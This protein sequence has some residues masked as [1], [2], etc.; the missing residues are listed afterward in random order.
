MFRVRARCVLLVCVADDEVG[1]RGNGTFPAQYYLPPTSLRYG[2]EKQSSK[3]EKYRI[4]K[5]VKKVKH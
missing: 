4:E 5:Y 1:G 3:L 2:R